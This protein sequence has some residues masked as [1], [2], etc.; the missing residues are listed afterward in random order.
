M[1]QKFGKS[2]ASVIHLL[3]KY[4]VKKNFPYYICMDNLF[5]LVP[6]LEELKINIYIG[7]RT[8]REITLGKLCPLGDTATLKKSL[9]KARGS[10]QTTTFSPKVPGYCTKLI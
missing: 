8:V 3:S 9:G 2:S 7:T 4:R 10:L 5:T 1:E 6:L